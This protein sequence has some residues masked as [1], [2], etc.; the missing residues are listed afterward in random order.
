MD[1][2]II[3]TAG[4]PRSGST[5]LQ[6][7]LAQ[8]PNHH[9]TS[10][11]GL[12]DVLSVVRD[13]WMQFPPFMSQGLKTIEPRIRSLL[14]GAVRGFFQNEF[15][16]GKTVFDKSRG[17]LSNIELMEQILGRKIRVIVTVRDI[18]DVIASFEK[19]FRKSVLTDHPD[20][21][22]NVYRRLT[23][24]GRAERL[25][26]IDHTVGYVINCLEDAYARNLDDRLIIIPYR[27]LTH[28][29]VKT[30]Q[31]VCLECKLDSFACDP[32]NVEQITQE[33][34]TVYGMEL[35]TVRS[36]VEPDC[37][38]SWIGVLPAALAD[39]LDSQYGF[40]QNLARRSYLT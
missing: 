35:H 31:R 10:T 9:C 22:V 18:R 12:L 11:N 40:V 15:D 6:N 5:L 3:F 17:Y 14:R 30:V 25:C 20:E 8:H 7:L 39:F 23:I 2:P 27:E 4:L 19:I 37:G 21:G 34:D 32:N 13:R 33:D 29:P 16:A 28:E 36:A 26:S 24:Q 38:G 1:L